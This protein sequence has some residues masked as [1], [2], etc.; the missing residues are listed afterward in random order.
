MS[1]NIKKAEQGAA[2]NG[3]EHQPALVDKGELSEFVKTALVA[4]FVALLIRSILFEP[5]NIPSSS[6]KPTLLVGDYL[7]VN[8]PAYGYSRYSF[9]FG[10]A[11][12]EQRIWAKEPQRGDVIVFALPTETG[13]NYIKRI[14]GLPGDRIKVSRGRLYINDK[15][16]PREFVREVEIAK[17]S[18]QLQTFKE[19]IEV[20]P[21][22][23]VHRIYEENDYDDL[24]HTDLFTVP[25]MHYFVMGDN[26]D[27]SQDSRVAS[28]VG[29]VPFENI[30]G[31]ADFLFFSSNGS[32]YLFE[33]WKWPW[34]IRFG[35]LF[36]DIDPVRVTDGKGADK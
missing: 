31:R 2:D 22:G 30:V 13:V 9:P 11:P 24:D 18:G 5:F 27:N 29:P 25:E 6:M 36:M 32:A 3:D 33:F 10:I 35:R 7:F 17:D 28:V 12:I 15:I 19:Y 23:A 20:L 14:I 16:V 4:V 34:A 1:E 21:G 8:K 26:R